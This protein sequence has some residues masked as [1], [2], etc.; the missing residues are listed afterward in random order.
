VWGA[1]FLPAFKV[2]SSGD[3]LLEVDKVGEFART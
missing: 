1:K 3:L 2:E